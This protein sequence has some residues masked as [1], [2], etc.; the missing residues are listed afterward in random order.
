MKSLLIS[1][2]TTRSKALLLLEYV[3]ADP[4]V[5]FTD[6]PILVNETNAK[7]AVQEE[8]WTRTITSPV[9]DLAL[10][11]LQDLTGNVP[12]R[13]LAPGSKGILRDF[14]LEMVQQKTHSST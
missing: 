5:N 9:L 8:Y 10:K 2:F 7:L 12:I 4:M 1:L 11:F 14:G 13:L 3:V 6:G